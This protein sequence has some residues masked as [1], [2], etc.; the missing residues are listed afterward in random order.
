[1][2]MASSGAAAPAVA[3]L[4]ARTVELRGSLGDSALLS[5]L[6]REHGLAWIRHGEGLVGWGEMARIETS[7]RNRFA[8]AAN[9]WRALSGQ[10]IVRDEV[11]LPGTGPIAFG[12]FA[13]ADHSDAVSTLV[14]PEVILGRKGNVTWITT[15]GT[16][17]QLAGGLD[18][19]EHEVAPVQ[20]PGRVEFRPGAVAPAEWKEKVSTAVAR[21]ETGEIDKVV[22]ARD[23]IARTENEVDPRWILE[24]LAD[25]YPTCWTFF[26][27]GMIGATPEMLLRSEKGLVT[28]RVLAGTIQRTG[29]D[30]A[31]LAH[32]A[33]LARSSKDLEEHEYS[34]R[35][36]AD[37]L[38]PVCDSM[39]V[40]DAPF[41]LHLPNVMHLASDVT[42]VLRAD[43]P[44][45]SSLELAE[46]LHPSAAVCGTPT[47]LADDAIAEIEG[48]DRDRYAGPV[49]WID[50][51]GDGE[52]GIALRSAVL[53]D[54]EPHVVRLFAGCGI[55]AASDPQTE[56]AES[57]AKL[58]PM[59]QALSPHGII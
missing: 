39:N 49:G 29:D 41:V 6:P 48:M 40:P 31:D 18:L 8:D 51:S 59:R 33:T 2:S 5:Y 22:L 47:P 44:G 24:Q 46:A 27:R 1:M 37:V 25:E 15:I 30:E 38:A 14:V 56:L 50:G 13:F 57:E 35:S 10:A 36:V 26:V 19:A 11:D 3:P 53:D 4:V 9:W 55:V 20:R 12:T 28:S 7:G 52:W 21:I 43:A 45:T 32:A 54:K 58:Q 23:V 16:T 42:G 17:T 34:V